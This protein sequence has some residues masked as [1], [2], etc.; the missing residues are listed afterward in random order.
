MSGDTGLVAFLK[1]AKADGA[2]SKPYWMIHIA[3]GQAF[4]CQVVEVRSDCVVLSDGMNK[5]A[6][7]PKGT[8]ILPCI[9]LTAVSMITRSP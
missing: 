9:P 5:T 4:Q 3:G 6:G 7:N 1:A 2:D 8:S